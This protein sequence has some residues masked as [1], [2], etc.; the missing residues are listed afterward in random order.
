MQ[1]YK[2]QTVFS[3]NHTRPATVMQRV[4]CDKKWLFITIA[5]HWV[6]DYFCNSSEQVLMC[7]I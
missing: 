4:V 3:F 2:I 6:K 5:F 1:T 7:L